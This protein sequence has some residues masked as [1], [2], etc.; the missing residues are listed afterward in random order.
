MASVAAMAAHEL[1]MFHPCEMMSSS[2]SSLR[3]LDSR[4]RRAR[5]SFSTLPLE[6]ERSVVAVEST[7][8]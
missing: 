5:G 4:P 8:V 3:V 1:Q 7:E 6:L 2:E